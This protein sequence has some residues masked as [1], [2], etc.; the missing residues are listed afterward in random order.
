MQGHEDSKYDTDFEALTEA[1][2]W[3]QHINL[4]RHRGNDEVRAQ[5]NTARRA[6]T[7]AVDA[8]IEAENKGE[9]KDKDVDA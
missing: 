9:A 2:R 1:S 3:L 7:N 4:R 6:I 8:L 5:V